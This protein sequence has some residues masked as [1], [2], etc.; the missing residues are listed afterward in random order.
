MSSLQYLRKFINERLTAAAE[1]IFRVFEKTIVQYE[2]EIN[3]QRKLLDITWKPEIEA[4]TTDVPQQHVCHED[5]VVSDQQLC[6]QERNSGPDREEPEPPQ[7]KE[8]EEELCISQ[9]GEPFVVKLEADFFMVTPTYEEG[10]PNEPEPNSYRLLSYNSTAAESREQR[11]S[12]HE[13]S[14]STGNAERIHSDDNVDGYPA[15][16]TLCDTGKKS[17]QCDICGKG[18]KYNFELKKHY[19]THT[20][21]KLFSC[22]ICGKKFSQSHNVMVHM[23]THTAEKPFVCKTCG[24]KFI[25]R[26]HLKS[27]MR[28]HTG[29]KRFSCEMCGKCFIH[30]NSLMY[31]LRIHTGE[32]PFL[33]NTCGKAFIERSHLKKHMKTHTGEK[34]HVCETC[35][36]SFI[37]SSTLTLHTRI[38]TGEKPYLCNTCGKRFNQKSNLKTHMRTHTGEKSYLCN[39]CGKRFI[40]ASHLKKHMRTHG[41]PE[42]SVGE[43]PVEGQVNNESTGGVSGVHVWTSLK[44]AVFSC[45]VNISGVEGTMSSAQYLRE[46]I[47]ERLTA[48][49]EEIFGVFAETIVRY[50]EE[51][52]RQRRLLDI[53]LKPEI[54]LNRTDVPQQRVC[55]DGEA[56]SDLR[57]YNQERNF[58]L[59]REEPEPPQIKEEEEELCV[60]QDGERLVLDQ[61]AYLFMGTPAYEESDYSEPEPD[62]DE[63]LSYNALAAESRDQ[64]RREDSG[65]TGNAEPKP[66][67]GRRAHDG[68]GRPASESHGDADACK[69]SVTCDICGKVFKYKFQLKKHHR[70]H[71]GEKP[72]LCNTCG[73]RFFHRSHLNRHVRTHTGEKPYS[74][75]T[76]GKSFCQSWDLTLHVRTHTGE[77]PFACE[78]CG[79]AFNQTSALYSHMRT[80]AGGKKQYA[81]QICDKKFNQSNNL[82]VH[83]RIHTDEKPFL[84]KTCGKRFVQRSQL[85]SHARTHTGEKPYSCEL[86]AK[87]FIHS[88][89]LLCHLRTHTGEKPHLCNTCGKRFIQASHLKKHMRTHANEKSYYIETEKRSSASCQLDSFLV[90]LRRPCCGICGFIFIYFFQLSRGTMSSVQHLRELINERLTA[91]AE[92]ILSVFES[93]IA[94]YEEEID[95]QRRLL[96]VTWKPEIKLHRTDVPQE[97]VC[98]EEEEDLS[99]QQLCN[100]ERNSSLDQE[101]PEPPQIKEEVEEL[102][103]SQEEEQLKL[104]QET[105]TV[106]VTVTFEESNHSEPEANGDQLLSHNSPVAESRDQRGSRREDSG[107][108]RNAELKP[109]KRRLRKRNHRNDGDASPVSESRG[110]DAGKKSLQ[111]DVCGKAFRYKSDVT[112]H[113]RTHTG[114][115]PYICNICGKRFSQSTPLKNH[116]RSHTGEKQYSCELCGQ[117]FNDTGSMLYHLRTHTGEKPFPCN[118]C[119]KRFID[120]SHLKEHARIHTG[121]R[122]H[123]CRTC[124]RS[125]LQRSGL[126]LHTRIHTGEKPYACNTCGKRFNLKSNLKKHTRTHTGEKPYSCEACDKSFIHS[127]SLLYHL[128]TH[129]G[130]KPYPCPACGKRFILPAHLTSHMKSHAGEKSQ[131]SSV[132]GENST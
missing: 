40:Q 132:C 68:D 33:C 13:D 63:L 118:T 86:C 29:E 100:Q 42:T 34:S 109:K 38:H 57:L 21:E 91:A 30:S 74:C 12:R 105:E 56:V 54:K 119:G 19:R 66:E 106:M 117:G 67:D 94:R 89:S 9:D 124:G 120:A 93:T 121:D 1:E 24:K 7:I 101:E 27:H 58:S 122:P 131:S 59:D 76:C 43:H 125:F 28:T 44:T 46:F 53:V 127:N 4:N 51:I 108:T 2:E 113:Y 116:V 35:G 11:G 99:D 39:T 18:F 75:D 102:S 50:E 98:K 52:D 3:R 61:E 95:R 114:E 16:A 115:K 88:Y 8:E 110:G 123:V 126:T 22:K 41:G 87:S 45:N 25:Q 32:K 15:S 47:G 17:A 14:G 71:T 129:T 5:E 128:R 77:K 23:R 85:N 82:M 79:K 103:I 31:H 92:E 111:C 49:A 65:S 72:F 130:E 96:D 37:Q 70:V 36:K 90:C 73:K 10:E 112:R 97:N 107:S 6:N 20:G 83:T 80:H 26:S 69:N 104:K 55:N 48:A 64:S 84:C 81:C 62:G 78:T 60:S